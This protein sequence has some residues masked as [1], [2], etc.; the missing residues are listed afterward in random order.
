V[1]GKAS[2]AAVGRPVLCVMLTCTTVQ[3][4]SST[5]MC[6]VLCRHAVAPKRVLS[7]VEAHSAALARSSALSRA[8]H[9]THA[10]ALDMDAP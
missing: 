4:N 6:A 10:N 9:V 1:R 7:C 8:L 5:D 2:R 3:P